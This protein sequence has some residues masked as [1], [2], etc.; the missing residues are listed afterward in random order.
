MVKVSQL[1]K[2]IGWIWKNGNHSI[3]ILIYDFK[4][5]RNQDIC[6]SKSNYYQML[7]MKYVQ[8]IKTYAIYNKVSGNDLIVYKQISWFVDFLTSWTN[9]WNYLTFPSISLGKL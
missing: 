3:V 9:R 7:I 5:L 2:K 4:K 1:L 6:L 8:K